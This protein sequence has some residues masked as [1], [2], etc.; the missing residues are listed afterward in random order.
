VLMLLDEFPAL[1]RLPILS[2]SAGFLP[3]YNV[4]TLMI[5]QSQSQLRDVYGVDQAKTLMKTIAARVNFAP[6]DME[7]AEEI[8]RELGNTT[9][10]SRSVSKPAFGLFEKGR[11]STSVS[12]SE[13]KRPL[14]LPQEV[15]EM[16]A[17]RQIIFA[18]N[19]RPIFC[20]KIRYYL[21]PV[22]LR[23]MRRP[24]EVPTVKPIAPAP[25]SPVSREPDPKATAGAASEAAARNATA[26]AVT[27]REVEIDAHKMVRPTKAEDEPLT[28]EE[29]DTA[30]ESFVSAFK[31]R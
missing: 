22:F 6:R 9:V 13:Q 19:V 3:G 7:D 30:V 21:R 1:G 15:K 4:R 26:V 16:G 12:V 31:Q 29:L 2:K 28:R 11:R 17:Q 24:P 25:N 27:T 8:S 18:E 14:M 20:H 5:M 10:K 23:R